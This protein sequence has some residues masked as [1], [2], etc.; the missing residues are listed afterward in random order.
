MPSMEGGVS[1]DRPTPGDLGARPGLDRCRHA[2]TGAGAGTRGWDRVAVACI[3]IGGLL[4]LVWGLVVHPPIDYVYSDMA[5]YVERA[6]DLAAGE[7]PR[8]VDAFWP[9]GTHMLLAVPLRLFGPDRAG[10]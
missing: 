4:R 2:A 10:L 7:T 6:Q 3:L 1:P 9:P 5:G 8:R